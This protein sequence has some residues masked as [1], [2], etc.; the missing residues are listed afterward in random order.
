[1]NKVGK[2]MRI[3]GI[4]QIISGVILGLIFSISSVTTSVYSKPELV[5]DPLVFV[6]WVSA[7]IVGSSMFIAVSEIIYILDDI[8][9][10]TA[11]AEEHQAVMATTAKKKECFSCGKEYD[12]DRNSCPHCGAS[13]RRTKC[14]A[15][16]TDY[17]TTRATCPHCGAR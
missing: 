10:N 12:S 1:V 3:L 11:K 16:G 2:F 14:K 13:P 15:C 17:D 6:I 8:R 4:G 5:F 7:G 9:D